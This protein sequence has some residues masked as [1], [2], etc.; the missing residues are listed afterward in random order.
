MAYINVNGQWVP[1]E[2]RAERAA[3]NSGINAVPRPSLKAAAPTVRTFNENNVTPKTAPANM[4]TYNAQ[5]MLKAASYSNMFDGLGGAAIKEAATD[6]AIN[7]KLNADKP[8]KASVVKKSSNYV[9][10][11]EAG[12]G[13]D[14][15]EV[16]A[17]QKQL[18][19]KADGIWGDK[20]QA[21][22]EAYANR[23]A[24]VPALRSDLD[25]AQYDD[26]QVRDAR[27]DQS[28]YVP[29]KEGLA[30]W[31]ERMMTKT[32]EQEAADKAAMQ[33]RVAQILGGD[34]TTAARLFE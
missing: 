26:T 12:Q 34:T 8:T 10:P 13:R 6:P 1:V 9:S 7:V 22:Y 18:G 20:T 31:L 28:P 21:A 17:I 2:G 25:Q 15:S 11:Y 32:P 33:A 4:P 23:N 16:I 14:K 29:E 5:E 24:E 30:G 19:V 3:L 27:N